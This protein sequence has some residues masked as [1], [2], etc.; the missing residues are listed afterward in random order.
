LTEYISA[1]FAGLW[2][3]S[4]E[5]EE[6]LREVAELC[7]QQ[8]WRL[9]TW[10][11]DR[12]LAIPG[13]AAAGVEAG[14]QDPLAA[15]R[16]LNALASPDTSAILVLQ[17]FHRFLGNPEIIDALSQQLLLGKQ[18][19]AIVIVLAPVVQLPIELERAFTVIKHELLP[20]RWRLP[21]SL[22]LPVTT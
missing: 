15:I 1:C 3:Q 5:P 9:A 18:T 2:V 19:R 12:G 17:N 11:L 7:R 10:N 22:Y 6:A 21:K 16:S 13:Q 8:N 4:F 14:G 20:S